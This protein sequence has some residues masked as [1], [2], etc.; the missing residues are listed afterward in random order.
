MSRDGHA[1]ETLRVGAARSPWTG[2][3]AGREG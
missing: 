2:N 1:Q 3:T